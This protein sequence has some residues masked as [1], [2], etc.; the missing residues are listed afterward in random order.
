M[1]DLKLTVNQIIDAI[2]MLTIS[3]YNE[4]VSKLSSLQRPEDRIDAYIEEQRFSNGRQCPMCGSSK[5]VR[6]G[7]RKDGVQ[8]RVS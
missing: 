1:E 7:K 4:F 3:E 5:V 2:K 6:N 8:S